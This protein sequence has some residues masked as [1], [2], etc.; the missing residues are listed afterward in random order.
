ML[1]ITY[2]CRDNSSS[3]SDSSMQ[4]SLRRSKRAGEVGSERE[5]WLRN[6]G[7]RCLPVPI[8]LGS[9]LHRLVRKLWAT[10]WPNRAK[11]KPMRHSQKLRGSQNSVACSSKPC[12]KCH[13]TSELKETFTSILELKVLSQVMGINRWGDDN[14]G[15]C[16]HKAGDDRVERAAWV[17]FRRL[18]SDPRFDTNL[19]C[20]SGK[21]TS[22][23]WLTLISSSRKK[24]TSLSSSLWLFSL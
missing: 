17:R 24:S 21:V 7:G 14:G 3:G 10:S 8:S 6:V 15:Q 9:G 5:A 23:P 16:W 1:S 11:G 4:A 2:F 19:L 12:S 13:H 22:L 18:A 20:D